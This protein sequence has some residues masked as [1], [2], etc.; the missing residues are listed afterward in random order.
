MIPSIKDRGDRI[1]N[2]QIKCIMEKWQECIH[3][4]EQRQTYLPRLECK[5]KKL[6]ALPIILKWREIWMQM[7]TYPFSQFHFYRAPN[8]KKRG[9]RVWILR[10][11]GWHYLKQL[12]FLWETREHSL[13]S[14]II[15]YQWLQKIQPKHKLATVPI[16]L[17]TSRKQLQI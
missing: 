1:T 16:I 15:L 6:N 3:S 7:N 9:A 12:Y 13:K 5:W 11:A 10:S 4:Q 14:G 2:W 17:S 8:P